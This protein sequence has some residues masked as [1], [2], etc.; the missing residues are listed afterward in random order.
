MVSVTSLLTH[1]K[2]LKSLPQRRQE[3]QKLAQSLS[4]PELNNLIT[5]LTQEG[6]KTA[7]D[8]I[9]HLITDKLYRTYPDQVIKL[10]ESLATHDNWEIREEAASV[11]KRLNQKY[12]DK[13]LP[14]YQSWIKQSNPFLLRAISVGLIKPFKDESKCLEEILSLFESIIQCDDNYVKK[15][16]GPFGLAAFFRRH[17]KTTEAKLYDWLNK[18]TDNPTVIWN[19]ISV[20]AQAN[21]KYHKTEGKRLIKRV[22]KMGV[23]DKFPKL[24]RSLASIKRK[25]EVV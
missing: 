19:I 8:L 16:A 6:T 1:F 3:G 4:I 23:A 13:L 15:N 2:S 21:A 25:L 22:E 11:I 17:P 7:W 9:A 18:Y 5:Q 12:F 20:F 14:T 24:K 10:I